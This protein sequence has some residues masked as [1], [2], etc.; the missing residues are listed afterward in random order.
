[1]MNNEVKKHILVVDDEQS[2]RE[3][4]CDILED[5]GFVVTAVA[6]G[7]EALEVLSKK[8]VIDLILSDIRMPVMGG[9]KLLEKVRDQNAFPPPIIFITGYSDLT[10]EQA[11]EKGV[12]AYLKKPMSISALLSAVKSALQVPYEYERRHPRIS[13]HLPI[14]LFLK[15][16]NETLIAQVSVLGQGGIFVESDKMGALGE[17][18]DFQIRFNEGQTRVISG[19]GEIVW[20][21]PLRDGNYPPGMGICFKSIFPEDQ[22]FIVDY[23]E[24]YRNKYEEESGKHKSQV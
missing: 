7:I 23:V 22:K 21:R 13:T 11:F 10:E 3:L 4:M 19:E 9:Q 16:K 5:E 24:R 12:F 18:V 17:F 1:M 20:Q 15:Q 14:N 8:D 2:I 6:N